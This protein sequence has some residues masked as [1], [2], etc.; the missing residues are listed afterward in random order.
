M[1]VGLPVYNGERYLEEALDSLLEQTYQDFELIISDNASTDRTEQICRAYA[2]RDPRIRYLRNPENLG[3]AF[4]YNQAFRIS[5]GEFF[6]W[7]A[8]D[9]KCHPLFLERCVPVLENDPTVVVSYPTPVDIDAQGNVLGRR[10]SGLE[11]TAPGPYERFRDLMQRPHA[12]LPVFGLIRSEAL[13]RT[14]LHL[15]ILS[16]DRLLLAELCFQGKLYELTEELFFHREHVDRFAYTH[17]T[18]EARLR[19]MDP[20]RSRRGGPFFPYWRLLVEYYR[21]IGRSPMG[22]WDKA[23]CLAYM[24]RWAA[25]KS[26]HL[27]RETMLAARAALP[28]RL[29]G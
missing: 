5:S 23:R 4:N 26:P 2:Q 13:R 28:H 19:W 29:Q 1:S 11:I 24:G 22:L 9:D 15:G 10:D 18:P 14:R 3:A 12:C 20:I 6:R 8:H 7:H 16:G 17:P 27:R 25:D 21:A